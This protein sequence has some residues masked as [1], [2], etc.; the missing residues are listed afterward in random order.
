MNKPAPLSAF[1]YCMRMFLA[2]LA[3]IALVMCI[4]ALIDP[5]GMYR[6]VEI[7]GFN[8]SKPAI[9]SRM[10]LYKAFEVARVRPQTLI[11]GSSRT[12]VGL[13]C[14]HPALA[15]LEAPCYNLAFDGATTREMYYYL[16]HAHAIRPLK[17]V[18][19]GLDAYHASPAPAT[20]RPDFDPLLLY[21]DPYGVRFITADLRI[22]TSLDTLRASMQTLLA[23]INPGPNWFAADGQRMGDI[24]FRQVE[25]VFADAG[26]RAYFDAIDRQ[27]VQDQLA[28]PAGVKQ[29]EGLPDPKESSLAY[30][31]R[32][33]AFCREQNIDLR[34]F[35]TPAHAH[36]SEITAAMWGEQSLENGKRALVKLLADDAALHPDRPPVQLMDFSGYSSIT[37]ESLPPVGSPEEMRFYWDSSH[38]KELAGD[39]VLTRLFDLP[40]QQ[41]P[42]PRDF[43]VNLN[44]QTLDTVLAQ[45]K[46]ARAEYQRNAPEDIAAIRAS[47][48]GLPILVYHQIRTQRKEPW[49]AAITTS[50]A[51][52]EAQ[53][54]YLHDQ[55]YS[56]LSTQEVMEYLQ[57]KTFPEKSVA[58]HFDDGWKSAQDA[59]PVLNKYGF[60]A[61]FWIIA[62]AGHDTGSPHMDWDEILSLA[63]NP[64]FDI[65]SHT[66]SHPWENGATLVDWV[67]GKTP[68]KTQENA[69]WEL[70]ESRR[71]LEQKLGRHVPYLA[72]PRGLYNKALVNLAQK[73]GYK[74]LFTIDDGF[75]HPG[76]NPLF[77]R[78]TMIHGEC[79]NE[80]F[81]RILKDGRYRNCSA[82]AQ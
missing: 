66:M 34:I 15:A 13:R 47:L 35:I 48:P 62:G 1:Y 3:L 23:Q 30:V 11:L 38:F 16:I 80:V 9:Y 49:N 19:L 75:N 64:R 6:K 29:G 63:E 72:W 32:I 22:M 44:A 79:D 71:L 33:L 36:Q 45:Q 73:A 53:M 40:P 52:F 55:G 21:P 70:T 27:E 67:N 7:A 26:P 50:L 77:I 14:S 65:F 43:G 60:K 69:S 37:T 41:Q 39:Y 17:H 56:T 61:S 8:T 78:R 42:V 57:G 12:H 2:A 10:R 58:I 46:K 51:N 59:V 24:F 4:N 82:T 68:G 74:A 20:T 18:V 5:F 31:Q 76:D 28:P 25:P 81:K 54:R